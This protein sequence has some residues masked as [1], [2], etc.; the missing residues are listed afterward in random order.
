MKLDQGF[1]EL[2]LPGGIMRCQRVQAEDECLAVFEFD[3]DHSLVEE[4]AWLDGFN[5]SIV[6]VVHTF[7]LHLQ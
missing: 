1:D 6:N 7:I 4:S 3:G 2:F 5:I